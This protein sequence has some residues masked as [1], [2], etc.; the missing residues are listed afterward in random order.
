MEKFN[1]A[2]LIFSKSKTSHSDETKR[3]L[4]LLVKDYLYNSL[5]QALIKIFTSPHLV[6]KCLLIL[7]V[8]WTSGLA[9]Y[10]VIKSILEYFNYGVTTTSRRIYETS[11]LFPKVTFCNVNKLTTSYAFN[12]STQM[13]TFNENNLD[14]E[15]KKKLVHDLKDILIE[16]KFNANNCNFTEFTWSY[17]F[18]RGN[19]YTF[20]SGVDFNEN[21]VNLRRSTIASSDYGLKLTLYVNIYEKILNSKYG[22]GALIRIGNSSYSTYF[23]SGS[24]IYVSPGFST[25][26]SVDREF[27]SML[28][29]SMHVIVKSKR[30]FFQTIHIYMDKSLNSTMFI[31]NNCVF[32][33]VFKRI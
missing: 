22:L 7:F 9:S 14:L 23:P 11:T 12:L 21:K 5:A 24:G 3:A 29:K 4:K 15:E 28:S 26:I 32:L 8:V 31:R 10:M 16:C 27:Q 30:D 17:D 1:S 18:F 2:K 33:N 6:H 13:K 25:Y 20:Y 19:C